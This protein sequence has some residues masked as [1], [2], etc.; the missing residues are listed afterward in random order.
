MDASVQSTRTA[1]EGIR[2]GEPPQL[3]P[4]NATLLA[5]LAPAHVRDS[6]L[7]ND[8]APIHAKLPRE[9]L[10]N[11]F[12][13]IVPS[14]R[15]DIQ[16]T[17]VCKLWRDLIH[18]TPEFWVDLLDSPNINWNRLGSERLSLLTSSIERS[19]PLPYKMPVYIGMDM[20]QAILP[21]AQRISSLLLMVSSTSDL[22]AF[23]ALDMPSLETL[24]VAGTN[25]NITFEGLPQRTG[26]FPR[27]QTL[28]VTLSV[29][30]PALAS[31]ALRTLVAYCGPDEHIGPLLDLFE[32]CPQ[33]QSL[34]LELSMNRHHTSVIT[35]LEERPVISLSRLRH[36]YIL[37]NVYERPLL[38]SMWVS[39]FLQKVHYPIT[40]QLRVNCPLA[41]YT[42]LSAFMPSSPPAP[43]ICTLHALE[44]RF[45]SLAP[46]RPGEWR[47]MVKGY[48]DGS[49]SLDISMTDAKWSDLARS[50]G[51]SSILF[52]LARSF[53]R[54]PSISL[55]TLQM[56]FDGCVSVVQ[57]DWLLVLQALPTL[58]TFTVRID[59]A[60]RLL[61]VLRKNPGLCPGLRTLSITCDNGSGV[62]GALLTVVEH[63]VGEGQ[64]LE[65]LTFRGNKAAPLSDRRLE[66]LRALVPN[67]VTF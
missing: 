19:A 26:T 67:F 13:H 55:T 41:R 64:G 14:Y 42:R 34:Q 66:R 62:H 35:H 10:M 45:V 18:R 23:L 2:L 40:A 11:I 49:Q 50:S 20:L 12:R 33:L 47:L 9:M 8:L 7:Q 21:H 6:V 17:H 15:A 38:M 29:I 30:H 61:T 54:A 16:F 57:N 27:V 37:D 51:P 43:Y 24:F 39:A 28:R 25:R 56:D 36:C 58:D 22:A 48:T 46:A 1:L 63:R 59:S 32:A 60:N 4:D 44:V 65:N 53:S 3:P 31:P 5:G 52:D